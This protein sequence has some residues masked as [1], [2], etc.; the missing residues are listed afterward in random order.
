MPQIIQCNEVLFPATNTMLSFKSLLGYAFTNEVARVQASAD[1]GVNWQDLFV[2]P[3]CNPPG[4][5]SYTECETT[6]TTHS[7]SL[8][9][10]AG[11]MTLLRFNY[12]F[13]S[14]YYYFLGTDNYLGWSVENIVVTNVQQVATMVTNSTVST[15][16]TFR[17]TQPGNYALAAAPVLFTQFP[18]GWGPFKLVNAVTN[19]TP[20][21]VLGQPVLIN[22]QVLLNFTVSGGSARTFHLLQTTN[23]AVTWATNLATTFTTNVPGSSYRFTTTNNSSLQFYAVQ[24]P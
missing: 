5:T 22:N 19:S 17:P 18:V 14:P 1:G 21:I 16:F 13:L 10:Y 4:T 8:S 12:D 24:T 3:G 6:F 7:L 2:D 15:N 9:N 11:Q 23:L 20:T